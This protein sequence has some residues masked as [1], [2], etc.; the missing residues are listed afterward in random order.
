MKTSEAIAKNYK[1]EKVA[2][3]ASLDALRNAP[4]GSDVLKLLKTYVEQ[5]TRYVEALEAY[6][7]A[8]DHVLNAEPDIGLT[9]SEKQWT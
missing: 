8:V 7:A 4:A 9:R 5:S 3:Y 6:K 2:F 1:I